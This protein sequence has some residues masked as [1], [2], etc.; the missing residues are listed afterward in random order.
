[1]KE[2]GPS[3]DNQQSA[4]YLSAEDIPTAKKSHAGQPIFHIIKPHLNFSKAFL[5]SAAFLFQYT[6]LY[7]AQNVQSVLFQ[8][9]NYGSLGFIS[10]AVVYFG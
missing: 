2:V 5:C 10:N 3:P 7:S 6:A 1:M 8:D 9:D 4:K